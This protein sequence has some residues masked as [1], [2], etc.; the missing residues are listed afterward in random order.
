MILVVEKHGY[1]RYKCTFYLF[2]T[3]IHCQIRLHDSSEIVTIDSLNTVFARTTMKI[4][5]ASAMSNED[6]WLSLL[7]QAL[8]EAE[9]VEWEDGAP[10]VDAEIAVA[11]MPPEDLF[12]REQKIKAVFNMGAGVDAL[13]K[14]PGL[15]SDTLVVRLE[16]AGM[17][18]QMAEYALHAIL[19]FSR[20]F[21]KY[22]ALQQRK[23][24]APQPD[25]DR[26]VW[27]VG[28]LGMGKMGS[29]VAEMLARFEYPVAG[30][31]R[32]PRQVDG[33]ESFHGQDQFS[34]FLARTRILI[35]TLPLTPETEGILNANTLGQ[36][37]AGGYLVSMGRGEHLVEADLIPL[38]D[39]GQL[40]GATL[41][42]FHEEPLPTQHPFW[43]DA[44]IHITPHV[45][46]ASLPRESVAQISEKIRQYVAGKTPS[47]VVHADQGY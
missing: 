18:I 28:V 47:G 25:I 22:E 43:S 35:N 38:L 1:A 44:R 33:V 23:E 14:L 12:E 3:G 32:S 15:R 2:G 34:D 31:S 36:L 10:A 8:P 42:V 39:S 30:W 5:Y 26:Q 24:W 9:I 41:D 29:R 11:W 20:S 4:L 16:D 7:R 27:P 13:L 21:A 45:A 19:R 46:A 40:M 17:S 6:T 37:Q